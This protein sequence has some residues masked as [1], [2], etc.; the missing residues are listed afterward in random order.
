MIDD[1]CLSYVS[2][3]IQWVD[4]HSATQVHCESIIR[5]LYELLSFFRAILSVIFWGIPGIN[6]SKISSII[7]HSHRAIVNP[8]GPG[9]PTWMQPRSSV[10]PT[11]KSW[12]FSRR[13]RCR[14]VGVPMQPWRAS[15]R[16]KH[17]FF[18]FSFVG[19][20]PDWWKL[21]YISYI[22]YHVNIFYNICHL[23][24]SF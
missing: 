9:R 2:F 19:G 22:I 10:R 7:N 21:K 4:L 17:L 15:E 20:I 12:S 23:L 14:R 5:W 11:S 6:E 13:W 18:L 1:W 8:L 24:L 3:S 16:P